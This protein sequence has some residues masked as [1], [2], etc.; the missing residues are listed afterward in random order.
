MNIA[1]VSS[2]AP[3]LEDRSE[4]DSQEALHIRLVS[5]HRSIVHDSMLASRT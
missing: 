5:L 3:L 1:M 4:A 2:T